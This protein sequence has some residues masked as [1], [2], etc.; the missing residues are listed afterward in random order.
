MPIPVKGLTSTLHNVR[1]PAS[2]VLFC[3]YHMSFIAIQRQP[4]LNISGSEGEAGTPMDFGTPPESSMQNPSDSFDSGLSGN[5]CRREGDDD[6]STHENHQQPSLLHQ[7]MEGGDS[8]NAFIIEEIVGIKQSLSDIGTTVKVLADQVTRLQ[9]MVLPS[10]SATKSAEADVKVP[11]YPFTSGNQPDSPLSFP[12]N[13]E[14]RRRSDSVLA[15]CQRLK[16]RE[17]WKLKVTMVVDTHFP[18][19]L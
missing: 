16:I 4:G 7:N 13:W 18:L 2:D 9:R 17:S 10:S 15:A 19:K 11:R 3:L 1:V 6:S 5:S 12:K 14:R 8:R